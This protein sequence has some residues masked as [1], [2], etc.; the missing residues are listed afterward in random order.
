MYIK[1]A[2]T[3]AALAFAP[4]AASAATIVSLPWA[5]TGPG[6]TIITDVM[7]PSVN[8]V[9]SVMFSNDTGTSIIVSGSA[10]GSSTCGA[11]LGNTLFGLSFTV[12]DLTVN[13]PF[14]SFTGNS[15]S[16]LVNPLTV[17][18][19]TDFFLVYR[20]DG[21]FGMN[22]V[23]TNWELSATVIPL[24]AAGW[25]L[26]TALGGLAVAARKRKAAA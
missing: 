4:V 19:G 6:P 2:L 3:A 13:L 22:Q 14:T 11:C 23:G 26:L 8:P 10:S 18:N 5:E 12:D 16:G 9:G 7:N 25:L 21:D 20:A 17:P 15:G 1:A 24:P